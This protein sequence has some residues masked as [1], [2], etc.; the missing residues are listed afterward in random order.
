MTTP[1]TQACL[2]QPV[3]RSCSS[4]RCKR[5]G[6]SAARHDYYRHGTTTLFAAL[7]IA[8]GQVTAVLKPR[9]RRQEFLAFLKQIE[10]TYRDVRGADGELG[11]LHPVMD[12]HAAHKHPNVKH[13]WPRTRGSRCTSL[14]PTNRG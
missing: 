13:G 1:A 3:T 7:D 14:R 4:P 10:R 5:D 8:T 6:S 2:T 11:D 9:H 12:N